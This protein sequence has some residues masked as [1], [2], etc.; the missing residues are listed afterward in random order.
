M[1]QKEKDWAV[2][3]A[4]PVFESIRQNRINAMM[5]QAKEIVTE[6]NNKIVNNK[7]TDI[8]LYDLVQDLTACLTGVI[9]AHDEDDKI[10]LVGKKDVEIEINVK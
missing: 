6:A 2:N 1:N 8:D 9:I 3:I 4:M 5:D 7:F 10:K